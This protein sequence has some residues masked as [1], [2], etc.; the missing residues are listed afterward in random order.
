MTQEIFKDYNGYRVS[1]YGYVISTQNG[2]KLCPL[3]SYSRAGRHYGKLRLSVNGVIR[4]LYI[5]R[6]IASLFIGDVEGKQ[7]DHIDG[8]I[9]NNNGSNLRIVDQIDNLNNRWCKRKNRYY[10]RV[11]MNEEYFKTRGR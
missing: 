8:D 9:M 5:H 2:T 11:E 1:S 4:Q 10:A 3:N 7:V 6:L